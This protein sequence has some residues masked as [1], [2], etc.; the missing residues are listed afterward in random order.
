M[1]DVNVDKKQTMPSSHQS[2]FTS[3]SFTLIANIWS[4]ITDQPKQ[5]IIMKRKKLALKMKCKIIIRKQCI[6]VNSSIHINDSSSAWLCMR[7]GR[8]GKRGEGSAA[9]WLSSTEREELIHSWLGE[10][11]LQEPWTANEKER[12]LFSLSLHS[13]DVYSYRHLKR[14]MQCIR[15]AERGLWEK[16]KMEIF[17]KLNLTFAVLWF[18]KKPTECITCTNLNIC[19]TGNWTI[20]VRCLKI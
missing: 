9:A 4:C 2:Y 14:L 20:A 1:R 16:C 10:H 7:F 8:G 15:D 12:G 5:F 3:R 17:S 13:Y 11:F 6:E 18:P 19:T